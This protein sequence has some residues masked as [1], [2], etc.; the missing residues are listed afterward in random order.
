VRLAILSGRSLPDVRGRVRLAR[1]VYGGCHGLEIQGPGVRFRHPEARA[2]S[3]R[4]RA[5]V[6]ALARQLHRFPGAFLER[7]GLSVSLHYRRVPRHLRQELSGVA[8]RLGRHAP[9][10]TTLPGKDVVEF[11]PLVNWDK[12]RAAR[13]IA[14][15]LATRLRP[16][17]RVILYAGDDATDEAA[18]RALKGR[19]L[20]IRVGAERGGAEYAV[21]HV[22]A[23]HALLR[24]I[25]RVIGSGGPEGRGNRG[26]GG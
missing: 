5:A 15:R 9:G 16:R 18:F 24:R 20:T 19:G 1:V 11:L 7:K 10:L 23:I 26:G 21:R 13:W 8:A 14:E 6:R 3:A 12:G 4:V 2:R 17:P 25:A 22:R